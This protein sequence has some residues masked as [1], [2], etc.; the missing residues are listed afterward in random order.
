[1]AGFFEERTVEWQRAPVHGERLQEAPVTAIGPLLERMLKRGLR[2]QIAEE[3][4]RRPPMQPI[5]TLRG[6]RPGRRKS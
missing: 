6:R 2:V 4:D 1:M 5:H 3:L